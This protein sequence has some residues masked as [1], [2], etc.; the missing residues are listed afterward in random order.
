MVRRGRRAERSGRTPRR[1]SLRHR[2]MPTPPTLAEHLLSALGHLPTAGQERAAHALDRLLA[3]AKPQATLVLKGYAGTGKTTL[4]GAL[5]K[6]LSR[7]KRPVVLMAPTGRA[8]KVLSAYA[9]APA[10]T[11]HRRIYRV[12]ADEDGYGGMSVGVNKDEGALF[13]VDEASMIGRSGGEGD[14]GSPAYA[15]GGRDLLTD[16]F[17]HVFSAPGCKL[18]LIGDPAQLPPVG[19]PHSPA[20]DVKEL[21]SLG[22]TAGQVEMTEVVRQAEASGILVNATE[23]RALLAPPSLRAER[24]RPP[25]PPLPPSPSSPSSPPSPTSPPSRSPLQP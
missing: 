24:S 13:V 5:V 7:Q 8:A 25:S 1:S 6:V 14:F 4:V 10:S 19:S 21:A 3:S 15:A 18:L 2:F 16:L 23:L 17:E 12:S 11:I 20:L 22:L 9:Q